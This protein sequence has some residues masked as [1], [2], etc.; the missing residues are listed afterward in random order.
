[1]VGH[2]HAE[3]VCRAIGDLLK[4]LAQ[5]RCSGKISEEIFIEAVLKIEAEQVMP[6][7]LTLTA[8]NTIDN[9][10]VFKLRVKSCEEPCASFEFLPEA[11]EFRRVGSVAY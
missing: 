2:P 4:E 9:W 6:S 5:S 8:S 10:I 1:M 11:G 3:A 7:G